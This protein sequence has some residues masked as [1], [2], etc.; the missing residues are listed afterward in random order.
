MLSH[1][2]KVKVS[3]KPVN[4]IKFNNLLNTTMITLAVSNLMCQISILRND[5]LH[6]SFAKLSQSTYMNQKLFNLG[7]EKIDYYISFT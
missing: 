4:I 7:T 2:T 5:I 1:Y 3:L 6:F